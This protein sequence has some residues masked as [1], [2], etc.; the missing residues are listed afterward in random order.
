[1]PRAKA[2]EKWLVFICEIT[3]SYW[4]FFYHSHS[5]SAYHE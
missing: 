5:L 1:M 4:D 2:F 3:Q